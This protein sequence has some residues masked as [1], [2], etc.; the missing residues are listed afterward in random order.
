M[1][2]LRKLTDVSVKTKLY[3]GFLIIVALASIV[4]ITGFTQINAVNNQLVKINEDTSKIANGAMM[5][6]VN[7]RT[8]F[9]AAVEYATFEQGNPD[10]RT[11]FN[12]AVNMANILQ[13]QISDHAKSI[14]AQDIVALDRSIREKLEVYTTAGNTLMNA[15]DRAAKAR[16]GNITYIN[17]QVA[18]HLEAFDSAGGS[19]HDISSKME[20]AANELQ[21]NVASE[22]QTTVSLATSLIIGAI[23]VSAVVS[24]SLAYF[25]TRSIV[26]PLNMLVK[27]AQVIAEGNLGYE[28]KAR[29]AHDEI[30]SLI[31]AI[32]QMVTSTAQPIQ[33]LSQI[34]GVMA[35]GDLTQDVKVEAKGDIKLLV[36]SFANM[37]V[38]LKDIVARVRAVTEEVVS[39][40]QQISSSS[41]EMNASMQQV[42]TA[43][44]QVAQGAQKLSQL[45]QNTATNT[46]SLSTLMTQT[47]GHAEKSNK[48]G[49]DSLQLAKK[50]EEASSK[51]L[52]S[53]ATI[54]KSM[55]ATTISVETM[56]NS[57]AKVGE[58]ANMITDVGSQTDMLALNAAVEAARA[59]EAGR[60][61]AVVADAVKELAEQSDKAAREAIGSIKAVGESGTQAVEVAR[62]SNEQAAKGSEIIKGTI[63]GLSDIVQATAEINSMIQE[64]SAGMQQGLDAVK[65]VVSAIEEISSIAQDSASSSEEASSAIEQQ[66][67]SVEEL[68]SIAQKLMDSADGLQ[69]QL[70]IFKIEQKSE[71]Q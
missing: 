61:F 31:T 55:S 22:A 42:S 69:K 56:N 36:D 46:S 45:A 13:A 51:A 2:V 44:Q 34:A 50:L 3:G 14:G 18:P 57:I 26:Q 30:G 37:A 48:L 12:D 29:A 71:N 58:L 54:Q 68:S 32:K 53:I 41:E 40:S 67:A 28:M 21:N 7:T 60:G 47:S 4:G 11:E 52:D 63:Q 43:S 9:N 27:D 66:T 35:K 23:S 39:M 65:K 5:I 62:S 59:G 64:V 6:D 10:E 49:G 38:S 1:M 24:F 8:A 20:T 25:L 33:R 17:A 16:P 19:L 70:E 15:Y